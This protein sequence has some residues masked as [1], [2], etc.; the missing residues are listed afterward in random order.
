MSP[1]DVVIARVPTGSNVDAKLRPA[2]IIA[3]LPGAVEEAVL[4]CGIS[5][6]LDRVLDGWDVL[7]SGESLSTSGLKVPSVVWPSWLATFSTQESLRRIGSVDERVVEGVRT[8][9]TTLLRN[10]GKR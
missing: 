4:L 5:S 1:G 2:L 6:R 3:I 10:Q 7:L 9:L 8:L